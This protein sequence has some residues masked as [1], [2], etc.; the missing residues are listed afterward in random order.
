MAKYKIKKGRGRPEKAFKIKLKAR[1]K[2][3]RE[4]KKYKLPQKVLIP[5]EILKEEKEGDI[6]AIA[7]YLSDEYGFC[8]N[9]FNLEKHKG[10]V[11]TKTIDWDITD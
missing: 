6:G 1:E 10:K 8:V 9:S 4:Y 3:I 11:Y 7:D 2:R 5:K